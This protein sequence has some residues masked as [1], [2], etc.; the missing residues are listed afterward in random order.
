MWLSSL[1][2][3]TPLWE[4]S[5][6]FEN[7]IYIIYKKTAQLVGPIYGEELSICQSQHSCP[8]MTLSHKRKNLTIKLHFMQRKSCYPRSL[9][10]LQTT[11]MWGTLKNAGMVNS[12]FDFFSSEDIFWSKDISKSCKL[13]TVAC[14]SL[15]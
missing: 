12:G 1:L 7:S 14:E 15:G 3:L 6:I 13:Q 8:D 4:L 2:F 10:L 9:N 11:Q 5:N